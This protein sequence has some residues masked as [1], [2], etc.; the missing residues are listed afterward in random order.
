MSV[1]PSHD[2]TWP[3]PEAAGMAGPSRWSAP[4]F[5]VVLPER[6]HLDLMKRLSG[7]VQHLMRW[8]AFPRMRRA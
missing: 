1:L 6:H 8:P 7:G 3:T 4:A 5:S 2:A